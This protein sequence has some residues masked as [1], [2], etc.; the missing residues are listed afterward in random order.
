MQWAMLRWRTPTWICS[1]STAISSS[2]SAVFCKASKFHNRYLHL[3]FAYNQLKI[4]PHYTSC[5][6]SPLEPS[7]SQANNNSKYSWSVALPEK[8]YCT[9]HEFNRKINGKELSTVVVFLLRVYRKSNWAEPKTNQCND[10]LTFAF[11]NNWTCLFRT[12]FSSS[13]SFK[14]WNKSQYHSHDI[15]YDNQGKCLEFH[16]FT[17]KNNG[18]STCQKR[19]P[20][21]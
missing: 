3:K 17:D 21:I 15:R 5:L 10:K 6:T 1:F 7:Y 4:T 9:F 8:K 19:S 2:S 18:F 13:R 20:S 14:H 11:S 16:W 12:L